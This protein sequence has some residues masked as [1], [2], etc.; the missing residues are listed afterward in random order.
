MLAYGPDSQV[1][2]NEHNNN[3][4]CQKKKGEDELLLPHTEEMTVIGSCVLAELRNGK[5]GRETCLEEMG[6][7]VTRREEH[8]RPHE[9]SLH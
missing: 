4:F 6:R 8:G 7:R 5:G 9:S 1:K 2:P 3:F